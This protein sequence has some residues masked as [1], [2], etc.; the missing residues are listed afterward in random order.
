MWCGW[1]P[2]LPEKSARYIDD[3]ITIR[4]LLNHSSGIDDF[5]PPPYI[6]VN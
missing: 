6:P 1:L 4:Q 2:D 3:T 5:L